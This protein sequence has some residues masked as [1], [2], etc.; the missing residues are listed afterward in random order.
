MSGLRSLSGRVFQTRETLTRGES[1]P[2]S[3]CCKLGCPRR[4]RDFSRGSG[5]MPAGN[6]KPRKHDFQHF[7]R[8]FLDN[9]AAPA[10]QNIHLSEEP[11]MI[12]CS[13]ITSITL[14][15]N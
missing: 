8:T 7:A 6:L 10:I 3:D 9:S 1:S 13:K 14:S 4:R 2:K 5:V 15:Y 11:N 12:T